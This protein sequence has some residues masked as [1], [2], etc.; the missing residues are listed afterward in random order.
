MITYDLIDYLKS[1]DKIWPSVIKNI[2]SIYHHASFPQLFKGYKRQ[3][4]IGS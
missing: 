1:L 4:T 2:D 3:M